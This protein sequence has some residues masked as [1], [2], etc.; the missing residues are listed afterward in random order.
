MNYRPNLYQYR[1]G[2]YKDR[3]TVILNEI[4]DRVILPDIGDALLDFLVIREMGKWEYEMVVLTKRFNSRDV[5]FHEIY[6]LVEDLL[7]WY[8]ISEFGNFRIRVEGDGHNRDLTYFDLLGW[9]LR[10]SRGFRNSPNYTHRRYNQVVEYMNQKMKQEQHEYDKKMK[11]ALGGGRMFL[12][13]TD[14][15][16]IHRPEKKSFVRKVKD[17]FVNLWYV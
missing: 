5:L 2:F 4:I 12:E 8:D 10:N 11:L 1:N 16:V 13:N 17:Y 9:V 7:I 6:N 15:I 14:P 3:R